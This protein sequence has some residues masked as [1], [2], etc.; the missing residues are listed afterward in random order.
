MPIGRIS[1]LARDKG[2]GF[3]TNDSEA[4]APDL[5]IHFKTLARAGIEFPTIGMPLVY[6][7]STTA[8]P[9]SRR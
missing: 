1:R 5:F 4:G 8:G 3:V 9:R 7:V 6:E 2:F